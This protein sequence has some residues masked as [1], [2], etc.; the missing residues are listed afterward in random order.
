MS[1]PY[2]PPVSQL[3]PS[4]AYSTVQS[5]AVA[6]IV[7]SS[8]AIFFGSVALVIDLVLLLSGAVERL[9][10]MNDGPISEYTQITVRS[11]WGIIL[12][13]A[14][15]F[16]LYGAIQMRRLRNFGTAQAAAIVAMIPMLGPCCLIGIPFGIW[17]FI[18]LRRPEVQDAFR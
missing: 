15:L 1:N 14:S 3:P 13:F 5:P 2:Q 6:L 12:V 17:A 7:V 16:V 11:I 18:T 4:N 10:A 9:E 8:I